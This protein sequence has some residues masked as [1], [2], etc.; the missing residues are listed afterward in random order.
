MKES[1]KHPIK[2]ALS[3][4]LSLIFFVIIVWIGISMATS[5]IPEIEHI[6]QNTATYAV[7]I[8]IPLA[9]TIGIG[10]YFSKDDKKRLAFGMV[11]TAILIIYFVFVLRS[12]N[13]GYQGEEY[14]YLITIPGI[15]ILTV[16]ACIIR[17]AIYGIEYY[18]YQK[19]SSQTPEKSDIQY[20]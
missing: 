15:I 12:V 11:S 1:E 8:G 10:N 7:L 2:A 20:Y 16:I 13:L 6:F 14:A 3:F 9:I 18:V 4:V 17:G 5:A 19:E